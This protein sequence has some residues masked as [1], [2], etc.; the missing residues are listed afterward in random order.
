MGS[1]LQHGRQ[2]LGPGL[3]QIVSNDHQHH[4]GWTQVL[5]G[6][7][8]HDA[9]PPDVDGPAVHVT[10]G[11]RDERHAVRH[12]RLGAPLG[13]VYRVVGG[14]VHVGRAGRVAN[15]VGLGNTIEIGAL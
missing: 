13:A 15:L 5:L 11:V 6:S 2:P 14:E 10:G 8:V 7:R 9:V 1:V 3:H 4:T 12:R